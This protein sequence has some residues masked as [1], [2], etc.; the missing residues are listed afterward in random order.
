[1]HDR[2]SEILIPKI[3]QFKTIKRIDLIQNKTT[4]V[5]RIMLDSP[6]HWQAGFGG[7][8]ARNYR[9]RAAVAVRR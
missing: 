3:Y 4:K 2:N 5:L 1:M 6:C 8:P 9:W 7:R